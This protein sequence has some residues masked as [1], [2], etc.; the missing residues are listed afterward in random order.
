MAA[1]NDVT[2]DAIKSKS[3]TD[4]FRDNFDKIFGAKKCDKCNGNCEKGKCKKDK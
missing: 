3:T 4:K 1:V 2:G